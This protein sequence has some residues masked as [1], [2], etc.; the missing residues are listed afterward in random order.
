[1]L[2]DITTTATIRPEVF[3][4]TLQSFNKFFSKNNDYHLI[5]NIDAIGEDKDPDFMIEIGRQFF[6]H[7]TY[8]ISTEPNQGQAVIW[9]W[10]QTKA[11]FVF[12]LED[13]WRLLKDIHIDQML[14]VMLKYSRIAGLRLN[15][16]KIKYITDKEKRRSFIVY[17][18]LV[19]NPM[20]FRGSFIRN[21]INSCHINTNIEQQLQVAFRSFKCHPT[22]YFIG[23]FC[24]AGVGR[25]VKDVGRDWSKIHGF[26]HSK[27]MDF[28]TW[29][30]RK[31]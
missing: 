8:N 31:P 4:A 1:L 2:I 3:R 14:P 13:D 25:Y 15:K 20:L 11:D 16:N 28:T 17:S 24:A 23:I 27:G 26:R 19:L 7:I 9:T 29:K 10:K 6:D 22:K 12:H 5:I 21:I 30:R 18:K